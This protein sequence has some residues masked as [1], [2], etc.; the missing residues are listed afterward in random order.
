MIFEKDVC[1]YVFFRREAFGLILNSQNTIKFDLN[2]IQNSAF[3][4][5]YNPENIFLAKD[6]GGA[7]N[8]WAQGHSKG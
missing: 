5:L 7:G 3:S 8:N 1:L 2:Q 4:N 6:G